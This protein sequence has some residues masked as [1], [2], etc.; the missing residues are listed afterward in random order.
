MFATDFCPIVEVLCIFQVGG[1]QALVMPL[2]PRPPED[3]SQYLVTELACL[4]K[5]Y[6]NVTT[7]TT[8]YH[9]NRLI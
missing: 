9:R 5:D 2:Q 6:V 4:K 7:L 3:P 1:A 8:S